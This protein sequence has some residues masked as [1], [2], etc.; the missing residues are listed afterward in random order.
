MTK[1][2]S[3]YLDVRRPHRCTSTFYDGDVDVFD[4]DGCIMVSSM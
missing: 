3:S 2:S 1:A 4:C